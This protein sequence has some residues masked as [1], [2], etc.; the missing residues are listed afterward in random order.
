MEQRSQENADSTS[1]FENNPWL[2][3]LAQR[4]AEPG[5]DFTASSMPSASKAMSVIESELT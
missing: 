1:F 4:G 5:S 3:I 2:G